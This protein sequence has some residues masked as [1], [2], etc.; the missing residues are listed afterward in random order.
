MV[1]V[2]RSSST[3]SVF[4]RTPGNGSARQRAAPARAVRL[5]CGT[6][7]PAARRRRR[8][9]GGGAM[10]SIDS[11]AMLSSRSASAR[12]RTSV[13]SLP[14]RNVHAQCR[15][16][17]ADHT[18]QFLFSESVAS[19]QLA[20]IGPTEEQLLDQARRSRSFDSY[21]AHR[22][23]DWSAGQRCI[24]RQPD[25]DTKLILAGFIGGLPQPDEG[26]LDGGRRR[27]GLAGDAKGERVQTRSVRVIQS[28]D[29]VGT[30][31]SARRSLRQRGVDRF[32]GPPQ[33]LVP[34][35]ADE[36]RPRLCFG[37]ALNEERVHLLAL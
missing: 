30:H 12:V 4:S 13:M 33:P 37:Q 21:V 2:P 34:P 1:A 8:S 26:L 25:E 28:L 20:K 36:D 9:G 17:L 29:F 24:P 23:L 6:P 31:A 35:A 3:E 32:D 11:A 10:G 22:P 14:L 18:P 7:V 15:H 27:L 19:G 16:F 5:F